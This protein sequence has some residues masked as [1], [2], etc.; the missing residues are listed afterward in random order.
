MSLIDEHY[1][2]HVFTYASLREFLAGLFPDATIHLLRFEYS[3][4]YASIHK[5]E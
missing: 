1:M 3:C 2:G 5:P 4:I